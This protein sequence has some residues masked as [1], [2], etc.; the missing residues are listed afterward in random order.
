MIYLVLALERVEAVL[1]YPTYSV[2]TMIV[3]MLAGIV[4]FREKISKKNICALGMILASITL[5]N[6]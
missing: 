6:V 5:L 2:S 3:I 4:I 1:V